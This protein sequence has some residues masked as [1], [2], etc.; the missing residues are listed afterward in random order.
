MA[1]TSAANILLRSHRLHDAVLFAQLALQ[2]EPSDQA[3]A[4][5]TFANTLAA[6]GNTDAA[7]GQYETAIGLRPHFD[8]AIDLL[9]QLRWVAGSGGARDGLVVWSAAPTPLHCQP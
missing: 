8:V 4:H 9:R 3:V 2:T 1:F 5:L 7:A 6:Y